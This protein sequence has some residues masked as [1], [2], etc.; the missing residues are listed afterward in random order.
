MAKV[1]Q[2]TNTPTK[3]VTNMGISGALVLI[4]SFLASLGG[5]ELPMEVAIAVTV[6]VMEIV[7]WVTSDDESTLSATVVS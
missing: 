3:K 4:V 5:V 6:V 7:G 1:K 2:S